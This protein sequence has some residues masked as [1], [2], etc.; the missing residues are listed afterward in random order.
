MMPVQGPPF[1]RVVRNDAGQVHR[2]IRPPFPPR[3]PDLS[4]RTLA[5]VA[6]SR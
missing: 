4:H 2:I 6:A 1:I 5:E 3:F